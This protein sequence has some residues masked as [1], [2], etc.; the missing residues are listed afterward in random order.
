MQNS[1]M[2]LVATLLEWYWFKLSKKGSHEQKQKTKQK[3]ET[4]VSR[5]LKRTT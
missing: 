1:D 4:E 5:T 3:K 2:Y